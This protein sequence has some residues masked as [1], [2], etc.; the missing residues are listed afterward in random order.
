[1]LI[2]KSPKGPTA[3]SKRYVTQVNVKMNKKFVRQLKALAFE[4]DVYF[5]DL[6]RTLIRD[7]AER[8]LRDL[9]VTEDPTAGVPQREYSNF[10]N[11]K[12]AAYDEP[13]DP[14]IDDEKKLEELY[15]KKE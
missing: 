5:S 3:D 8:L 6:V 12:M 11:C 13:D 4:M 15:G 1:M 10:K 14:S 7:G 9:P 2:R